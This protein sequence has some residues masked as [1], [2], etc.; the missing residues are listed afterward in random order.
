[1]LLRRCVGSPRLVITVGG[2]EHFAGGYHRRSEFGEKAQAI[3]LCELLA[4]PQCLGHILRVECEYVGRAKCALR[5]IG[6]IL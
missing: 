2:D 6:D 4:C 3:A 5:G 1:M